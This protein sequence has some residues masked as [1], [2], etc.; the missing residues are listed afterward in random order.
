MARCFRFGR[1]VGKQ[2]HVLWRTRADLN[3]PPPAGYDVL[4]VAR[5]NWVRRRFLVGR[6]QV[7]VNLWIF[8]V[9]IA[10]GFR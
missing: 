2:I 3:P 4:P 8:A 1:G 7:Y 9:N 10:W 6:G 5:E